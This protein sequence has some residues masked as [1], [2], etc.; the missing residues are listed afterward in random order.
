MLDKYLENWKAKTRVESH[1]P[2]T[3]HCSRKKGFTLVEVVVVVCL[4]G[5]VAAA[6]LGLMNY[7]Q[8]IQYKTAYKK[9]FSSLSQALL[10]ARADDY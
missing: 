8:E 7:A 3:I 5:I 4:L 9:A 1:S 10:K 6:T 2:F